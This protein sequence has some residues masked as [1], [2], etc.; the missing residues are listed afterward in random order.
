MKNTNTERENT[1]HNIMYRN[2]KCNRATDET[3][4]AVCW[5]F[6]F[7]IRNSPLVYR[8]ACSVIISWTIDVGTRACCRRQQAYNVHRCHATMYRS[9]NQRDISLMPQTNRGV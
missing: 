1:I 4:R 8:I 9:V 5:Y 7:S 3:Y 2:G 6:Q